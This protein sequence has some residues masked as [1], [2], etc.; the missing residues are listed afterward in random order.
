[1]MAEETQR[2]PEQDEL[3]LATVKKI[4]PY[5]GFCA[6]PEYGN[7][8]AFLHVSEVAPRW[9]KN[10][11]EF[12]SENQKIVV[13][14]LRVD[15]SKGQIDVSLRRVNEQE[16][17]NKL[18]AV[19]RQSRAEKLVQIALEKSGSKMPRD[20][21]LA[22][23]EEG[24]G[25]AFAG[26]EEIPEGGVLADVELP[27]PLKDALIDIVSKSI[28]KARVSVCA[29]VTLHSYSNDGISRIIDALTF[30][31]PEIKVSYVGAPKY[32]LE[33]FAQDYKT[34]KKK[35]EQALSEASAR[36]GKECVLEYKIE[37]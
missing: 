1:M 2:I 8:E 12:L 21:L 16:K 10:I 14:V 33:Y 15:A 28:K 36:G 22:I 20:E 11:H 6:L 13:K 17:K 19:R 18:E 32:K 3:V 7:A 27:K 31:D 26:L 23:L 25:E 9:I 29:D 4:V 35:L 34:A 24:Y 37:E 30:S 5:G